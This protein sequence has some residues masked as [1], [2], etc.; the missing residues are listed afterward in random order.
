MNDEFCGIYTGFSRKIIFITAVLGMTAKKMIILFISFLQCRMQSLFL[1]DSDERRSVNGTEEKFKFYSSRN[2]TRFRYALLTLFRNLQIN[3]R[4]EDAHIG[5][6][7]D[8]IRTATDAVDV[9]CDGNSGY[10][11]LGLSVVSGA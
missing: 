11:G 3:W 5:K 4:F 9:C 1:L 10:F 8:I 6:A 2:L 7:Y